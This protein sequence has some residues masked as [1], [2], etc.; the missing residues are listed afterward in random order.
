MLR[1]APQ[2]LR[3]CCRPL[4]VT[5]SPQGKHMV[6]IDS[7]SERGGEMR[8]PL[9]KLQGSQVRGLVTGAQ[10][11]LPWR[12]PAGFFGSPEELL[13]LPRVCRSDP[14]PTVGL[15]RTCAMASKFPPST[16][17]AASAAA[18]RPRPGVKAWPL[19]GQG[20]SLQSSLTF[21]NQKFPVLA[22]HLLCLFSDALWGSQHI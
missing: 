11:A 7:N 19:W 12:P 22:H 9:C 4:P 13:Q 10:A 8:P 15:S 21:P 17:F 5:S 18:G 20:P 6:K 1:R 14:V 2:G 3:G 16:R